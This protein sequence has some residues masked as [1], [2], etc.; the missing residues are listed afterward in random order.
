MYLNFILTSR[1]DTY[2]EGDTQTVSQNNT[3]YLID[4]FKHTTCFGRKGHHQV[5]LLRI[6]TIR[7]RKRKS[8][9]ARNL[10]LYNS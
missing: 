5:S 4:I 1:C 6:K 10:I 8:Y 2:E 7:T 9:Y 3:S